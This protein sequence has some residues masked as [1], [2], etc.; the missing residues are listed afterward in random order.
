MQTSYISIL[1][2]ETGSMSGQE[3][4]VVSGINEYINTLRMKAADK[5]HNYHVTL[6]L[7][8]SQRWRKYYR[9]PLETFPLMERKDYTP[10]AM[11]PLYDAI[12]RTIRNVEKQ[13]DN[14]KV[15]IIIDTDGLEN[16]S[17]EVGQ[18]QVFNKI[19]EK[20]SEGWTF[21]FLGAEMSEFGGAHKA[22]QKMGL[23]LKESNSIDF[24]HGARKKIYHRAACATNSY[25]DE[26]SNKSD[27]AFWERA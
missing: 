19:K 1:L 8:D 22:Q 7:F 18:Q 26:K 10:G 20:E 11:T 6:N 21:V 3:Q 24:A 23:G 15:L 12:Y 17:R 25:M 4:R 13:T 14:V 9:G 5:Q 2:D 16:A 27:E